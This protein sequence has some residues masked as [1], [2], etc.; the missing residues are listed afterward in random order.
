VLETWTS[1]KPRVRLVIFLDGLDENYPE[2]RETDFILY[3]LRPLIRRTDL[4]VTWVLSSQPRKGMAWIDKYFQ[5]VELKGLGRPEAEKLAL[6]LLPT[7]F[8]NYRDELLSRSLIDSDLYDAETVVIYARACAESHVVPFPSPLGRIKFIENLPLNYREKYRWMFEHYTDPTKVEDLPSLKTSAETWGT[9]GSEVPYQKF[10]TD[11]LAV[12]ALLRKPIP[13]D[14]L[15]WAL[16]LED[17]NPQRDYRGKAR[18]SFKGYPLR[19]IE[20]GYFLQRAVDDLRRFVKVLDE[21]DGVLSFCKEAIRESFLMFIDE[22]VRISAEKR[23][24]TLALEEIDLLSKEAIA[25]RPPYLLTEIFYLLSLNP[26]MAKDGLNKLFLLDRFPEWLQ[27]SIDNSSISSVLSELRATEASHMDEELKIRIKDVADLISDWSYHLN[28]YPFFVDSFLRNG[29][30]T[31]NYWPTFNNEILLLV[32]LAGYKRNI[33]EHHDRIT[34]FAVLNDGRIATGS[35]DCDIR[36]W[37][38]L[39]CDCKVLVGRQSGVICLAVLNDGRLASG[40]EHG[41]ITIWNTK[42]HERLVLKH[43]GTEEDQ[44]LSHEYVN[45][46]AMLPDGSLISGGT[47]GNIVIWDIDTGV[48]I[49]KKP[50]YQGLSSIHVLADGR[51]T[52]VLDY[53]VGPENT[54]IGIW[55]D[56]TDEPLALEV[57]N[58]FLS[59]LNDGRIALGSESEGAYYILDRQTGEEIIYEGHTEPVICLIELPNGTI[60]TGSKDQTIRIWDME[61]GNSVIFEGHTQPV[62]RLAMLPDG[63]LASGDK[64][65]TIHLWDLHT[66]AFQVLK[67]H[68]REIEFLTVLPDGHLVSGSQDSIHS[69]DISTGKSKILMGGHSRNKKVVGLSEGYVASLTPGDTAVVIVNSITGENRLLKDNGKKLYDFEVLPNKNLLFLSCDAVTLWNTHTWESQI[70]T[71]SGDSTT[72]QV[73]LPN[74]HLANVEIADDNKIK[75]TDTVTGSINILSEPEYTMDS[76]AVLPNGFLASVSIWNDA[77]IWD[78]DTGHSE[79]LDA[80]VSCLL[81]LPGNY[82]ASG[83]FDRAV[84]LWDFTGEKIKLDKI[85]FL[86][87][88]ADKLY[89]YEGILVALMSHRMELFN[90]NLPRTSLS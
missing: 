79:V 2:T 38:P 82:L 56:R 72:A 58:R 54:V 3:I 12:M 21:K 77:R 5:V 14:V 71:E 52:F 81:P 66:G 7:S 35:D 48:P 89:Y 28:D 42:T 70:L 23:L 74:Q 18:P 33:N 75:I 65:G 68:E 22:N 60:A 49:E 44:H 11:V 34:C 90:L 36:I 19:I 8:H 55:D 15:S 6:N 78:I 67:G 4:N 57:S 41:Y 1:F 32:P 43:E 51:M 83:S 45:C 46:L 40:D 59:V 39:T 29:S 10:L 31:R 37:D 26:Q 47:W 27:M 62:Q 86:E 24:A 64:E 30:T 9:A 80:L 20:D 50:L 85:G 76:I 25:K 61:T 63:R 73:I 16:E 87:A 53:L 13:R 69:W 17:I 88:P 84:I